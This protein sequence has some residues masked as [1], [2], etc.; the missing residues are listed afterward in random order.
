MSLESEGGRRVRLLDNP[1]AMRAVAHPVRLD[2]LGIVGRDGPVTSAAAARQLGISQ[3]LASHHMR[4]LAKYGFVEPAEATNGRD[5]PW[6]AT[7]E[8]TSWTAAHDDPGRAAAHDVLEQVLA[9]RALANLLSWQER[10]DDDWR[11]HTGVSHSLIYLTKD[12]LAELTDALWALVEPLVERRRLGGRKA[13]RPADAVPVDL[14]FLISVLQPTE[15][16]N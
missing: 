3:A 6:Q 1:L 12:E 16:G 8:S 4:Q 13:A 11:D 15:A 9:E 7:A 5:R 2:L 10:R 14:T